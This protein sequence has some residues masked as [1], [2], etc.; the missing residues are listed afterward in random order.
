MRNHHGICACVD[1]GAKRWKIDLVDLFA[2]SVYSGH[3]EV[4]ISRS[5]TVFGKMLGGGEKSVVA[6]SANVSAY[7]RAHLRRIFT[8]RARVNDGIGWVRVDV[9]DRHQV[10]L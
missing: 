8:K 5:V 2:A 4:R 9:G 7:Q 1:G 6:R 3:A 10:P